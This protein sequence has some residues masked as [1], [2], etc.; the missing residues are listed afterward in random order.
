[1]LSA[2]VILYLLAVLAF[3]L[4]AVDLPRFGTLRCIAV[5]LGLITLA[6]VVR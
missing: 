4:G 5:G 2:Q 1:M 6:L 3:F